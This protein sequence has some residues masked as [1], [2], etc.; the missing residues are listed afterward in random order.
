[1]IFEVHICAIIQVLF[2]TFNIPL[3]CSSMNRACGQF[4]KSL[5]II[6]AEEVGDFDMFCFFGHI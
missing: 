2:N 1:M 4:F 6:F 5:A 3:F